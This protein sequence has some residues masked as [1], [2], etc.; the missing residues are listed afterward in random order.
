MSAA[1]G[2]NPEYVAARARSR[3]AKLLDEDQYRDL[4]RMGPSE[5][6]RFL[7]ENEYG[8]EINRMGARYNGVDLI[9]Y[10]LNR[11]LARHFGDLLRFSEGRLYDLVA[12]YLR[13][14]DDWNVKT[15]IRGV[16]SGASR[17]EI[18]DDLIRAG[19]LTDREI[20]R[21]LEAGSVEGVV[22]ALE[23]TVFEEGLAAAYADYE[24]TGSLVPIENAVDRAF[25]QNLLADLGGGTAGASGPTELYVEFLQAEVDF[26]NIRNAL[27]LAR[28]GADLDPGDYYIDG[29]RLFSAAEL[30]QVGT[31]QEQLVE[32]VRES[33]YGDELSGALDGL[34]DADSLV[35][36]ENAVERALLA[37]A[38]RLSSRYPLSV[39]PVLAYIV[40][41][42]REVKNIR[43]IARGKEAGL[44]PEAIMEE[45]VI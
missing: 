3:R 33:T 42:E 12:R 13:K 21:L 32:R 9:E 31:S 23:G 41:K 40:A 2:S 39:C 28:T 25:Y 22:E 11:N 36:F 8:E 7:E 24:A 20:G 18:E 6:A 43:A 14:F 44:D 17:E 30:S 15:V 4:V 5:I 26:L 27:R 37:Y 10:A 19:E 16:Y 29:G 38:D 35:E 34:A 1:G 45:L